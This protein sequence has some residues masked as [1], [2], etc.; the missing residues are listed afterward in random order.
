[1]VYPYLLYCNLIWGNCNATT[2]WPIFKLQKMAVRLIMNVSRRESTSKHFKKL[3]L[4]KVPDLYDV[5]VSIFMY[6]FINSNL[7]E[8][9][10]NYFIITGEIHTVSTRQ[11]ND[12]RAPFY[13]SQ[14]GSKFVKRTGVD[15]WKII[16]DTYGFNYPLDQFKILT[17]ANKL[18]LY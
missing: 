9:F 17:L 13:K 14:V 16:N 11:S 3:M 6:N 18:A 2:I 1:M 7:P 10:D 12:Y 15:T 8:T 5:S 4:L